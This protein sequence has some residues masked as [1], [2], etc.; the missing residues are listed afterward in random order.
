MTLQDW[1][2]RVVDEKTDLDEKI[3]K[4]SNFIQ[5][6]KFKEVK[7]SQGRLLTEQLSAMRVY[8]TILHR[9]IVDF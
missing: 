5:S 2:Q 3:I 9:R 4:L 6:N 8:S 7:G 1:Q